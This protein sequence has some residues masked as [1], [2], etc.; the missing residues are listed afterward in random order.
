VL[1]PINAPDAVLHEEAHLATAT[2]EVNVWAACG[3]IVLTIGL[4]TFT[5]EMLVESIE[6]VRDSKVFS[7]EWFGL[8]LLPLV[9]FAAD[10]TV[11]TLFLW[12]SSFSLRG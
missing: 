11:A 8:I 7:E 5:A 10:G 6:G 4:V 3:V 1:Q 12:V 9:S 2:P